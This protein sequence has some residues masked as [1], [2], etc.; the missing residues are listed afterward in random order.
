MIQIFDL[1][2]RGYQFRFTWNITYGWNEEYDGYV[3]VFYDKPHIV[4]DQPIQPIQLVQ[5]SGDD[6]DEIPF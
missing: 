5:Q 3:I 1:V 6:Y 2:R 4:W